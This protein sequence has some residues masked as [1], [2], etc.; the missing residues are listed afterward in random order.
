MGTKSECLPSGMDLVILLVVF[1]YPM[2]RINTFRIKKFGSTKVFRINFFLN[3]RQKRQEGKKR[4]K[5]GRKEGSEGGMKEGRKGGRKE[6]RKEGRNGGT[7]ERRKDRSKGGRKQGLAPPT[8][9]PFKAMFIIGMGRRAVGTG[10][11]QGSLRANW[12]LSVGPPQPLSTSRA[13]FDLLLLTA[14]DCQLLILWYVVIL[15]GQVEVASTYWRVQCHLANCEGL[16]VLQGK[17][18]G[19]PPLVL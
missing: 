7:E 17:P 13:I 5:E 2:M 3:Y 12:K 8:P 10:E 14:L 1:S 18:H 11:P 15:S 19:F 16:G 4:R 9:R 6:G